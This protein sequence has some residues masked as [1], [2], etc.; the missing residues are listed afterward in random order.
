MQPESQPDGCFIDT[1]GITQGRKPRELFAVEFKY[2]NSDGKRVTQTL[3][4]QRKS[5][6]QKAI[7]AW[8]R[9][10]SHYEEDKSTATTFRGVISW[11]AA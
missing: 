1:E 9:W 2:V 5:S 11:E 4:F 3:C 6:M 7:D 10:R 8:D